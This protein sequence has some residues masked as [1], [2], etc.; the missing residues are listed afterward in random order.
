M[1][2]PDE[3][4]LDTLEYVWVQHMGAEHRVRIPLLEP[5]KQVTLLLPS[6]IDPDDLSGVL[7]VAR[8]LSRHAEVLDRA[9]GE[10]EACG[11]VY[12]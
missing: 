9:G 8:R 3:V 5:L 11:A 6:K 7:Q 2:I 4:D 12:A 10:I 1:S